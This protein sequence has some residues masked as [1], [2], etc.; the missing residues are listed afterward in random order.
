MTSTNNMLNLIVI[1]NTVVPQWKITLKN[2]EYPPSVF[3][4]K[5]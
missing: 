4:F 1:I 5:N 2:I 3:A